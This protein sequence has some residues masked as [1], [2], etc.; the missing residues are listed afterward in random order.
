LVHSDLSLSNMLF[1]ENGIV[2]IDFSLMGFGHPMMD[3]GGLYCNINGPENRKAIA[4]GYKAEGGIID[5][6]LLDACFAL[7]ILLSIGLHLEK[8]LK[9]DW[10]PDRLERWCRETFGPLGEGKPIFSPD[11][12][13]LNVK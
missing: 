9:E 8:W 2:P 13:L 12:Y 5:F 4:D 7:N 1:T 3:L 10:F 11:Y 6:D